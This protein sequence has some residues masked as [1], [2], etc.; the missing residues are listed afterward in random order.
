MRKFTIFTVILTVIIVVVLAEIFAEEY[1]PQLSAD[2]EVSTEGQPPL[3]ESL[4][5]SK[6]AQT[7]VFGATEPLTP[8]VESIAETV[9]LPGGISVEE[10]SLNNGDEG[11]GSGFET[12]QQESIS[13][14]EDEN[15]ATPSSNVYLRDDQVKSAGFIGAYL[16]TS[17][18]NGFLFKTIYIDD[19]KDVK[20]EKYDIRTAESLLAKVYVF[21]I[22]TLMTLDDVYNTL[23]QRASEGLNIEVNENN[24]FGSGS[25]YLNDA[26]R[27]DVAFLTTK[28]GSMVYAFSYPKEYHQQ[29]KNLVSLLDLEF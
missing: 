14:F 10:V 15:Y 23:K 11:F 17:A 5:L 9:P 27:Q 12:P 18:H 13:D 21:K 7:N 28:I 2:S 25:F 16:Q 26:K 8:P 19:L 1:L 22:G 3:P 4:D 24:E 20:A 29:V 6:V